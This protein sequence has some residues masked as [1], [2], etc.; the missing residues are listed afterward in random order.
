MAMILKPIERRT[1]LKA[2]VLRD[3]MSYRDF[4]VEFGDDPIH[5]FFGPNGCGKS[6]V[7][8]AVR[9]LF[10]K[11]G[12]LDEL[13][14]QSALSK[15]VRNDG[16]DSFEI[17][18]EFESEGREYE[19]VMGNDASYWEWGEIK[20]L[21]GD[22]VRGLASP[23][24]PE[25]RKTL[26]EQVWMATYDQ[27]LSQFQI[28]RS[29]WDRFKPLF[30]SVTGYEVRPVESTNEFVSAGL[31]EGERRQAEI[32]SKYIL[33]MEIMKPTGA[34]REHQCSDGEKKV[35]KHFTHLFNKP[36]NEIP[37]IV[38]I[39]NIE[40]HISRDRQ[41]PLLEALEGCFPETQIIFTTHGDSIICHYDASRLTN[42]YYKD[43][44]QNVE[45]WRKEAMR[46]VAV[47]EA[48]MPHNRTALKTVIDSFRIKSREETAQIV[49]ELFESC[50]IVFA[51]RI[52]KL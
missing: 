9:L 24:L 31:T 6:T 29:R 7:L 16:A 38:L 47:A 12:G 50:G 11:F 40:M 43:L 28:E 22:V 3:F 8:K 49:E 42:L 21:E 34:I 35:I 19:V 39:D 41:L 2:L 27:Q 52:N 25:V 10:S 44:D 5:G 23:H 15:Y 51:E 30:E 26:V 4:R 37:S 48:L 32:M 17:R 46:I 36:D 33:G 13:R 18:G 20:G 14:L 1:R 45:P